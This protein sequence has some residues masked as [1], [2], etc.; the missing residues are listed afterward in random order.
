MLSSGI[1]RYTKRKHCITILCH[2]IE[3]TVAMVNTIT[4][5]YM[6]RTLGRLSAIPSSI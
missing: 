6:Q 4:A 3:N 5:T 2:A 1:P